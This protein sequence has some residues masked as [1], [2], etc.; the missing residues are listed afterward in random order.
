MQWTWPMGNGHWPSTDEL[1]H[2]GTSR[3]PGDA[4][5]I[6]NV[7]CPSDLLLALQCREADGQ[8]HR[9]IKS[10]S[11]FALYANAD[12]SWLPSDRHELD[13]PLV[14]MVAVV[15]GAR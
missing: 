8:D 5:A 3:W 4:G 12:M 11:P 2:E 9:R 13:A 10:G 6:A 7:T 15:V 14:A 1:L